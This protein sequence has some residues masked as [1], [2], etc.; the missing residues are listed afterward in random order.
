MKVVTTS[1]TFVEE[2]FRE[3]KDIDFSDIAI[4]GGDGLIH[5]V[6]NGMFNHP[7]RDE[8]FE[9][10]V[11]FIP[12][13]SWN[14]NACDFHGWIENHACT[15]VL[16]GETTNKELLITKDYLNNKEMII[17]CMIYGFYLDVITTGDRYRKCFWDKRYDMTA[18]RFLIC[19]RKLR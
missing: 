5:Q 9:I 16:W 17:T 18:I 10:P 15:N 6:L 11:A 1:E 7:W 3:L 2:Y 4:V 19:W 14:G 8:L 13:G 12:G